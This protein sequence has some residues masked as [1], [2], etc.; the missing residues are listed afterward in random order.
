MYPLR[1][2]FDSESAQE[3]PQYVVDDWRLV[4]LRL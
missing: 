4:T 3:L 1:S 2:E